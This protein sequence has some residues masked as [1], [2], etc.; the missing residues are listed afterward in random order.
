MSPASY[1]YCLLPERCCYSYYYGEETRLS[2]HKSGQKTR[3][4]SRLEEPFK[5]CALQK[6]PAVLERFGEIAELSKV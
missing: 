6:V 5:I 4:I 2:H 1:H 3:F